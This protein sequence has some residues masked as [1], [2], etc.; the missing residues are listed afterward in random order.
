MSKRRSRKLSTNSS[1]PLAGPSYNQ[2]P[3]RLESCG[4][5]SLHG[6]TDLRSSEKPPCIV[7]R[8]RKNCESRARTFFVDTD[9]KPKFLR[10]FLALPLQQPVTRLFSHVCEDIGNDLCVLPMCHERF[11]KCVENFHRVTLRCCAK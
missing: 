7:G 1:M 2:S 9:G 3:K 4:S 8:G 11:Q 5:P 6:C 10:D